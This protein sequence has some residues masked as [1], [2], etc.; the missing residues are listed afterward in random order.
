MIFRCTKKRMY[1]WYSFLLRLIFSFLFD[2]LLHLG[3]CLKSGSLIHH[4]HRWWHD[5]HYSSVSASRNLF[6][7]SPEHQL[8]VTSI[9]S[10]TILRHLVFTSVT[11]SS[12]NTTYTHTCHVHHSMPETVEHRILRSRKAAAVRRGLSEAEA[13]SELEDQHCGGKA[14]AVSPVHRMASKPQPTSP[15]VQLCLIFQLLCF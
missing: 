13:S 15:K 5:D 12:G 7:L 2:R 14:V 6:M 8:S 3:R 4:R 1:K 11:S 9:E 10:S